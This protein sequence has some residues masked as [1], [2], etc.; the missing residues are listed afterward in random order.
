MRFQGASVA[1]DRKKGGKKK[2]WN[3][4][5]RLTRDSYSRHASRKRTARVCGSLGAWSGA[6]KRNEGCHR[7][8][9]SGTPYLGTRTPPIRT[10]TLRAFATGRAR[11]LLSFFLSLT[12]SLDTSI[13]QFSSSNN[14]RR[15]CSLVGELSIY[16]D[17]RVD[18]SGESC[19]THHHC[20]T[21][22]YERNLRTD[23]HYPSRCDRRC[24][25]HAF[26][27]ELSSPPLLHER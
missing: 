14:F 7:E 24:T 20:I 8:A 9:R 21:R 25:V 18:T 19:A 16:H 4:E 5:A 6:E 2:Q 1:D 26:G 11:S 15:K 10:A 13:S 17:V 23:S 27:S 22:T 3:E 12:L